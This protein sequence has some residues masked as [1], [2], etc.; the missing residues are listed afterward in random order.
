MITSNGRTSPGTVNSLDR[1][2]MDSWFRLLLILAPFDLFS[3]KESIDDIE[4]TLPLID[5][6]LMNE[7]T[8]TNQRGDSIRTF[9]VVLSRFLLP[10][11]CF[12]V[13]T[14]WTSACLFRQMLSIYLV[15]CILDILWFWDL[16]IS[17]ADHD[18]T[19][20][21]VLISPLINNRLII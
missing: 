5:G 7:C 11:F 6:Q 10:W 8:P 21:L 4:Y 15:S 16:C 9:V 2:K 14:I 13:N 18:L 3:N 17:T 1:T 19:E 12:Y 20:N